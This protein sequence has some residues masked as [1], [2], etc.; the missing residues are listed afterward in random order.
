MFAVFFRRPDIARV[1]AFLLLYR[2]AEAPLRELVTPVLL[3]PAAVGGL[4]LKTQYVG[5][6]YGTLASRC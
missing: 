3:D 2:F 4:A 6:A 5:I 1:L